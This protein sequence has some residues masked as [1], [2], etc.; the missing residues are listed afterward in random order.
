MINVGPNTRTDVPD[1]F[2][3]LDVNS[4]LTSKWPMP[5]TGTETARP[6]SSKNMSYD[7]G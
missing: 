7:T 5:I 3:P 4:N 6:V 2:L 1:N